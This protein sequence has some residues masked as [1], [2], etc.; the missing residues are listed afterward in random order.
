M[1]YQ[2]TGHTCKNINTDSDKGVYWGLGMSNMNHMTTSDD[3][4]CNN[5]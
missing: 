3:G 1:T 2:L 5:I 4:P